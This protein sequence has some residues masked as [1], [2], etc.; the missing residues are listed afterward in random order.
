MDPDRLHFLFGND[1]DLATFDV[2]DPD[3]RALLLERSF[4]GSSGAELAGRQVVAAMILDDRPPEVW[5]TVLR[6]VGLGIGR[7]EVIDQI[8]MAFA[9]VL[10]DSVS[11]EAPWDRAGMVEALDRLPFPSARTIADTIVGAVRE[12]QGITADDLDE[13]VFERLGTS[14]DDKVVRELVDRLTD[15]LVDEFGPL[16]WLVDDRTVHVGDLTEGIVLTHALTEVERDLG[17]VTV[18]FDLAGFRRRDDLSLAGGEEIEVFSAE[19][20]HLAWKGPDG[21]LDGF[22]ADAVLAV[23]I[24]DGGIVSLDAV[25]DTPVV[26]RA[27]VDRLRAVYDLEEGEPGLPVAGEDLVLELLAGD[28]TTFDVPTAPLSV[29]AEAAGLEV[30]RHE[31]AHDPAVWHRGRSIGRM[32]RLHGALGWDDDRVLELVHAL[33]VADVLGGEDPAAVPEVDHPVD[34]SATR[35]VLAVLRDQA[36]LGLFLDE[37]LEHSE[38]DPEDRLE[39]LIAAFRPV[40]TRSWEVGIVH[41][42]AALLAELRSDLASAE[43]E[44]E[45]A[46]RADDSLSLVTDR[47]AWYAS[48]RGDAARAVRLWRELPRSEAAQRDA[49]EVE[50]FVIRERTDLGRND[51][52]WCGSGRKFKQCHLGRAGLPP[53]PERVGWLCRKSVAYLERGAAGAHEDVMD[54][55]AARATGT[56]DDELHEAFEDPIVLDLVLTEGGWFRRFLHA[57][58]ALLPE[59]EQLLAASW[60]LVDRSVFEVLDVRPG[61]GVDVRDLRTGDTVAVRERTFS[62]ETRTGDLICA[63]PVPDG[64]GHQFIGGVFTVAPGYEQTL[65]DLLDDGD[66]VEIARWVAALHRPPVLHTREGE[67]MVECTLEVEVG[68]PV[69]AR[70]VLDATYRRDDGDADGDGEWVELFALHE[71]EDI[72]RARLRLEGPVIT[73]TTSSEARADRVLDTVRSAL[74]D[75]RVVR[76]ERTPMDLATMARRYE[77][78]QALFPDRAGAGGVDPDD[79]EVAQ[80]LEAQRARY[81][82]RWCDESVPALH[83]L[84][85]R[86]AAEDPSRREELLRL[87]ADFDRSYEPDR[88]GMRP[89]RLRELLGL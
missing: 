57:R 3:V 20:G 8:V 73:V 2:A 86:Q 6:L 18:S 65:L 41:L 58:G 23:R 30:R 51:P 83:G 72:L 62:R 68:D 33:D 75:V 29:L 16:A 56:D 88:R 45:R 11:E 85:P 32:I 49:A 48:D 34:G 74:A 39:G 36:A 42:V 53:L 24:D 52:C 13:L 89:D 19:P 38:I 1:I 5:Q 84:T 60:T 47:L 81:E 37:L 50:S 43:S 44:L 54:V 79:P 46:H 31:V 76:D 67:P 77:V 9:A 61:R 7:H 80:V 35:A 15:D 25:A 82:E 71:D 66:P 40:A 14:P 22:E 64:E 10:R 70:R 27:L 17:I 69:A 26:D 59:D 28:R 87:L 12:R 78:E 55:T 63:R 4:P 21:W